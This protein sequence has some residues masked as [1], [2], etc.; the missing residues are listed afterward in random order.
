MHSHVKAAANEISSEDPDKQEYVNFAENFRMPYW[1]WASQ[2]P[3]IVPKIATSPI[4]VGERPKLSEPV[5][6]D[7]IQ[8]HNPLYAFRFPEGTPGDITVSVPVSSTALNGSYFEEKSNR[9]AQDA[10]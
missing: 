8:N 2:D 5:T 6:K 10:S 4:Y 3:E 9:A 1:D 7:G